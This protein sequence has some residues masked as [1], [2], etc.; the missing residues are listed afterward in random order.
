MYIFRMNIVFSILLSFSLC[1]GAFGAIES[2]GQAKNLPVLHLE[3]LEYSEAAIYVDL[4]SMKKYGTNASLSLSIPAIDSTSS[5][6]QLEVN[7]NPKMFNLR[8]NS[9]RD[10][11]Y[12]TNS[13]L[14]T[15]SAI[16]G[17]T[18]WQEEVDLEISWPGPE[19]LEMRVDKFEVD[20]HN[21]PSLKEIKF[22]PGMRPIESLYDQLLLAGVPIQKIY[23]GGRRTR[24]GFRGE[25]NNILIADDISFPEIKRVVSVI[26]SSGLYLRHI[27][28]VSVAESPEFKGTISIGYGEING[29]IKSLN[30]NE[31]ALLQYDSIQK[32]QFFDLLASKIESDSDQI[33]K[34]Y[35]KAY[36]LIDTNK[37]KNIIYA[38]TIL[39]KII[40]DDPDFTRAYIELAR[41]YMKTAK[42]FK[43]DGLEN[44]ERV[45]LLAKSIDPDLADTMVLLGYVYTHMEKFEEAVVEFERADQL[46]TDNLWLYANWGELYSKQEYLDEAISMYYKV[47]NKT[48]ALPRNH[49]AKNSAHYQLTKLLVEQKRYEEADEV[50]TAYAKKTPRKE[51]SLLKQ[52]ELRVFYRGDFDGAI[53]SY[54][55]AKK[56]GCK[57]ESQALSIAY[58]LKWNHSKENKNAKDTQSNYRRAEALAPT[59]SEL[60]AILS[61]YEVTQVLIPQLVELGR[62][63]DS[64]NARGL[65]PL[66]VLVSEGNLPSVKRIL[67]HGANVN[68]RGGSQ[69]VSPLMI[70][71]VTGNLEMVKLLLEHKA[72][73]NQLLP[74]GNQLEGWARANGFDSIADLI[75]AGYHT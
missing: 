74:D 49:N 70:A 68:H 4:K 65:S 26:L 58:F 37:K 14:V 54:M 29:H 42:S 24:R 18:L 57:K 60:M 11:P 10:K 41:Y 17:R 56:L 19:Y 45:L 66:S 62:D 59:N 38:K 72:D 6:Q 15:V 75:S 12:V 1:S 34:M 44:A 8:R 31:S 32:D 20:H 43:V 22:I 5:A 27:S 64:V 67:R 39:D 33:E 73:V 53:E 63:I 40:A 48:D 28:M 9:N 61:M 35:Q 36:R 71:V 16:T 13:V 46:G 51:C 30:N 21:Y 55:Q 69:E 7:K 52:A 3:H 2:E 23:K 47:A 25:H 50:Y